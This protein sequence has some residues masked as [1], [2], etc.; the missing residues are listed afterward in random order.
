MMKL[1]NLDFIKLMPRFMQDDKAVQGLAAAVNDI[2]P[3]LAA[4]LR[5]LST[6][7]CIDDLSDAELD[8]LAWELNIEWYDKNAPIEVKR[9]I[10]KDSD[11]THKTLGTKWAV[12][13]VINTYFGDGEISE[14]FEYGGEPGHFQVHSSNPTIN[15]A[16]LTEF[17]ALL[18]K[19]KRASA[20]LDAV[21]ISNSGEAVLSAGV[22][23]HDVGTDRWH[24]DLV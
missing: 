20:K 21:V 2:I 23:F 11:I 24:V 22:G 5:K 3:G 18:D 17:L 9:E 10:V 15:N 19:I 1:E 4:S 6:W 16:R 13:R 12:E 7:D 14:W 8:E